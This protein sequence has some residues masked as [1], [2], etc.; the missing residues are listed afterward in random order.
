MSILYKNNVFA[1]IKSCVFYIKAGKS[2]NCTQYFSIF[3]TDTTIEFEFQVC[4]YVL[5]MT[6]D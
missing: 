5:R 1:L 4:A 6:F 3:Q 2:N